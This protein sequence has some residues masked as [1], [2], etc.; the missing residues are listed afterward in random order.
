MSTPNPALV[1]QRAAQRLPRAALLLFCAAYVLPGVFGRDPWK[2]ADITAFGYMMNLVHGE[3]SWSAW[4]H[5]SLG[6][7]VGDGGALPYWLGALF[8]KG[9]S[10]WLAPEVAARLPF[11]LLMVA[12][13]ALLWYATF[14]LARSEDALPLPFAFGGEAQPLDYA[15]AIADGSL[16]ALISALGLLLL[17]HE[18]TP[19]LVQLTA[20]ALFLYGLAA[21]P[22]KPWRSRCALI[23]GLCVLAASAA[24]TT[25][26]ALALAGA[27]V[28]LRSRHPLARA[29]N[30]WLALGLLG[31]LGIATA[32]GTWAWRQGTPQ[33]ALGFFRLMAWFT[34]PVWPLAAWTLW[35][36]RRHWAHRHVAAPLACSGV[37]L[38]S[39]VVMGG[40]DRALMLA[41][42]G[43]AVLA[44]FALPTL[45][46][47]VSAAI[48]WFSVFFFTGWALT[49]WVVYLSMYT[50]LPAKPAVNVTH[51]VPGFQPK[52]SLLAL[53]FAL[54]GSMAWVA[55]VAWRT[56]RHRHPMWKSLVLPAGG[57]ALSWLLAMTLLLPALDQAFSYR[58]LM[59][60]LAVHVPA[61]SCLAASSLTSSQI[62]AMGLDGRWRVDARAKAADRCAWLL[63][64]APL[65]QAAPDLPGWTLVA[66]ERRPGDRTET[67]LI[68]RRGS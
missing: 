5:P 41:L 18:T 40:S 62:A 30:L 61:G 14:H 19:E 3:A 11:A 49:F 10:T 22:F 2:G 36:W 27:I 34:W 67:L 64:S 20:T 55:L 12:T 58:R 24:P 31:A 39:S 54:L 59:Q 6:G 46:R 23:A 17:G 42:P 52:F 66:R 57:V 9:L 35:R 53:V 48:D 63:R 25:A 68:Y 60:R 28:N 15:R 16:L 47:S 37:A 51:L 7:V 33:G 29:A 26:V 65:P 44:A 56:G 32:L 45:Q 1:T 4:L 8:I 50:G 21:A 13:L 38:I 43:M